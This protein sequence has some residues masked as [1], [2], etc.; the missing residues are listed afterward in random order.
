MKF[1]IEYRIRNLREAI[2]LIIEDESGHDDWDAGYNEGKLQGMKS[3]LRFLE[4]LLKTI[5]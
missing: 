3:E 5:G 1:E 4:G 2:R